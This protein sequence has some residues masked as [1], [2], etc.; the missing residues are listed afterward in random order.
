M[1]ATLDG[2]ASRSGWMRRASAAGRNRCASVPPAHAEAW[3][4]VARIAR[5]A[6]AG[7]VTC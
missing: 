6:L 1:S 3:S 4:T 5:Q 7:S 2:G